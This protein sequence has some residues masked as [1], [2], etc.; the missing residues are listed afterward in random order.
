MKPSIIKLITTALSE[1]EYKIHK[2]KNNWDGKVNY[3]ITHK[4]GITIRFEPSDNKTIQSLIN[5]QYYMINHFE[6]EIAKHEKMIEDELV[7]MHLFQYSHSK[8]TLNEIWNKAKEE[9]DQTIQGHTQSIKETKEV[10]VDLQEL[11]ALAT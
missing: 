1:K 2:G 10:I 9:Y 11:L 7:D 3:V 6:N 5:E 4:D 8:M